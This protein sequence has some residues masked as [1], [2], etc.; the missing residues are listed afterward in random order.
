MWDRS[1][2]QQEPCPHVERELSIER[3]ER[4]L[5]EGLRLKQTSR[6]DD[7]V[8]LTECLDCFLHE[9]SRLLIRREIMSEDMRSTAARLDAFGDVGKPRFLTPGQ[10]ELR[11]LACERLRDRSTDA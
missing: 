2:R 5:K 11:T 9:T 8:K 1:L 3:F 4:C 10:A 7:N 6:V